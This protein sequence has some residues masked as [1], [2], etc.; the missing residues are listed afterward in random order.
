MFLSFLANIVKNVKSDNLGIYT[1]LHK[2]E[3]DLNDFLDFLLHLC[4]Y[5]LSSII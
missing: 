4:P 2:Q 3:T 1:I 5:F